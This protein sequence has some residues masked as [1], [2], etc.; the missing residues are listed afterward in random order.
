MKSTSIIGTTG[1]WALALCLA[2]AATAGAQAGEQPGAAAETFPAEEVS[3]GQKGYGLSVFAGTEPERFEVEVLGVLHHSTPELSYILARLSGQ[4]LER[5]G[6]AAGMSGSPV[7]ID[8][9]LAGAVAFSYLFGLDAIAGIT[10]IGA[11]R[12]LSELP[13]AMPARPTA[14]PPGLEIDFGDLLDRDFAGDLLSRQID[15]WRAS[16]LS[17]AR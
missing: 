10:P 12:R 5:S 8:G 3:R 6:V 17:G 15:R 16:S 13:A 11:M 7:Y 1:I 2:G 9:R 4:D 14:A